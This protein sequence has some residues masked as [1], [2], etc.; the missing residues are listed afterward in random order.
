MPNFILLH[1]FLFHVCHYLCR[2]PWDTDAET[3]RIVYLLEMVAMPVYDKMGRQQDD[4][5][6]ILRLQIYIICM[7]GKIGGNK[8][9]TETQ[10]LMQNIGQPTYTDLEQ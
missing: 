9:V 7:E 1:T 8:F 10:T 5:G 2:A 6:R 4:V 3:E